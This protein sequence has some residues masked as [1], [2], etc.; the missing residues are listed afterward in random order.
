MEQHRHFPTGQVIFLL[1][2]VGA[3]I[4]NIEPIAAPVAST[5]LCSQEH[6]SPAWAECMLHNFRSMPHTAELYFEVGWIYSYYHQ[7]Y[8]MAI[9]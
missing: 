5:P 2:L 8:K 9:D 3:L 7:D 1:M 6:A 4:G